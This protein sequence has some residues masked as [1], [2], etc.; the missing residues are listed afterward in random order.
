MHPKLL[1]GLVACACL[2]LNFM[3]FG[4]SRS[5][6]DAADLQTQQQQ[7]KLELE[8]MRQ[9]IKSLKSNM[10]DAL[11]SMGQVRSQMNNRTKKV[12]EYHLQAKETAWEL[13]PGYF[14]NA[15]TYN[16][17]L[18]GPV[19]QAE[20]GDLVRIVLHNQ[21]KNATSL[22]MQ[23]LVLPQEVSGLPRSGAGL[24]APGESYAYQFI[25]NQSGTFFYRPQTPHLDQMPRGLGGAFIVEPKSTAKTYERDLVL[26]ISEALPQAKTAS[27]PSKM[28]PLFLIN[29]KSAPSIPPLDV[30][31]G[32]RIRFRLINLAQ[33]ACP[34]SLSGHKLEIVAQNGSDSIEPHTSRDTITINPGE[35]MDL[36]FTA[37]NPGVWSFSSMLPG[38]S[39]NQGKFP[40]GIAQVVRYA[41]LVK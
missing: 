32:E 38:Q 27:T 2:A 26:V 39:S 4:Q 19:L 6:D 22:Y 31:N 20:E 35:R 9:E 30:K 24:V 8:E 25:A 40:G 5:I 17:L 14:T 41:E 28:S 23:G 33:S 10:T 16:G 13:A 1:G 3:P 29:G 36:E 37:N 12:R 11:Q 15:L 7:E 34:L 21:L 18:P